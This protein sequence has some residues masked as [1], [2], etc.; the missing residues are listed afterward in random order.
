MK[1]QAAVL[2][3]GALLGVAVTGGCSVGVPDPAAPKVEPIVTALA[4]PTIAPGHDAEA[5]AAKDMPFSA[6]GSL[7]AG[8]PVGISDGLKE[9]PGWQQ[10][11]DNVAGESQYLKADGCL[12]AAKVRTNQGPLARQ[13]DKESTLGLFAYLDPTI[14]PGYL[15]TESLRWGS[16]VGKP[17]PSAEVM[18]L[19]KP[20]QPG[21]RST[22]VMARVFGTAASSVYISVAC[23]DDATLAA[24]RADVAG[25][26]FLVPP[27]N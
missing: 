25:R 24:A 11:K 12:V 5:V 19:L 2:V 8:V 22:A 6:G 18:V 27:S 7:A 17:G 10:V 1:A 16:E 3:A 15:K 4:T 21:V 23:P 26:L 9:A 20:G 14:L 13:D